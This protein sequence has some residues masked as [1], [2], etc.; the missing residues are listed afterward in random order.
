MA[1]KLDLLATHLRKIKIKSFYKSNYIT[2]Y[3]KSTV[4]TFQ[5]FVI[6]RLNSTLKSNKN[7]KDISQ[8]TKI[9]TDII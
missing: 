1:I 9:T 2:Q 3:M 5:Q 7:S 4:I 8:E 6:K